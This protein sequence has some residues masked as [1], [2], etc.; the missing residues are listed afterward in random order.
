MSFTKIRLPLTT[1]GSY[2]IHRSKLARVEMILYFRQVSVHAGISAKTCSPVFRGR[3]SYLLELLNVFSLPF[4]L[5]IEFPMDNMSLS[6]VDLF[7]LSLSLFPYVMRN[8]YYQW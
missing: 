7:S 2:I 3:K 1:N 5:H 4:I 8:L 6:F